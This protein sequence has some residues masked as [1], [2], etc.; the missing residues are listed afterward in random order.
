M[1]KIKQFNPKFD[2]KFNISIWSLLTGLA[3]PADL[4]EV[5]SAALPVA[6]VRTRFRLVT[7]EIVGLER[8]LG[9]QRAALEDNEFRRRM[10]VREA[11]AHAMR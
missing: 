6:L 2:P 5:R 9:A 4:P 8:R 10:K 7:E 11:A 3:D 1:T